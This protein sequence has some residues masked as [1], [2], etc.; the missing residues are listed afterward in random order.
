M[1]KP[2]ALL[3]TTTALTLAIG[4]SAWSALRTPPDGEESS[5]TAFVHDGAESLQFLL[6]S[7]DDDD[8][9]DRRRSS[10]RNDDDDRDDND[11][12]DDGGPN[13]APAKS[14]APPQ[15]P[16]FGN[17]APPHVQVN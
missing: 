2:L 11:D 4:V 14:V 3:A 13:P 6:A 8:D 12:D 1:R 5:F 17:G 9:D 15:N 16:L 7:D 10:H